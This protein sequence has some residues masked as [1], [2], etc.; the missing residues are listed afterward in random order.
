MFFC[1]FK[2][3]NLKNSKKNFFYY[4]LDQK[5]FWPFWEFKK[6]IKKLLISNFLFGDR[7]FLNKKGFCKFLQKILIFKAPAKNMCKKFEQNQR[8]KICRM[9]MGYGEQSCAKLISN[10]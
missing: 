6:N 1:L 8:Q 2:S 10:S 3:E 4:F 7:F 5:S 9:I